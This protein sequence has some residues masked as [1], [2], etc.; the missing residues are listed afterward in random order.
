[1]FISEYHTG[2]KFIRASSPPLNLFG[3]VVDMADLKTTSACDGAA[4][5]AVGLTHPLKG[6]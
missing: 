4:R 5:A 3:L 2:L 1:L 6:F